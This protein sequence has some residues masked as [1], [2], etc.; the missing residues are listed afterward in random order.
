MPEEVIESEATPI[1]PP[2]LL[3]EADRWLMQKRA[4]VAGLAGQ[5]VPH[6]ITSG[7]DYRQSKRDRASANRAIKAITGERTK[8]LGALKKAINDFEFE[9]R[10][11]L[12]P[13]SGVDKAYKAEIE[14][15]ERMVIDSRT[16]NVDEW[17]Q[18]TQGYFAQM[19]PLQTLFD[20]FA[21]EGKWLNYGTNQQQIMD[22][23]MR[24]VE[25]CERDL[26]TI[27]ASPYGDEERERARSSYCK[28]L[29]LAATMRDLQ[30][31]RERR[32]RIAAADAERARM[33][34]EAAEAERAAREAEE[35][36]RRAEEAQERA[37]RE[38]R[39]REEAEARQR[40]IETGQEAPGPSDE[41]DRLMAEHA[42]IT[43]APFPGEGMP[44]YCFLAYCDQAQL[45]AL[46][47]FAKA[48]GIHGVAKATQG[49]RFD[50]TRKEG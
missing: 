9:V 22:D 26:E 4:E 47:A 25:A 19:V 37:E 24:R 45:Q 10:E 42:S 2:A 29:D 50:L 48:R 18:A 49:R 39:V 15:W 23:V 34:A 40:R 7:E 27:A 43:A 33:Q 11:L 31:E 16:Q 41:Y 12:D 6:E 28:T 38:R 20:R 21:A 35:A 32:E 46:V 13:L 3:S 8:K 1:E 14:A 5:Y 44:P 36:S 17:Y 30:D